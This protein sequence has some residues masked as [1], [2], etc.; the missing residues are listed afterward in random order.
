MKNTLIKE[1]INQKNE[2]QIEENK[3][4]KILIE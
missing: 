3:A 4:T 1:K 2:S